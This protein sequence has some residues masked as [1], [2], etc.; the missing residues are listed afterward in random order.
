MILRLTSEEIEY[1]RDRRYR[2]TR[3]LRVKTIEEALE[4]V[5]D[6]GFCFAF[7]AR[8]SELP[9]LWHAACGERNP[10]MPQ[11]TH[12]DPYIGLVWQ[13]KDVLSAQRQIYY[14]KALKKRPTMISLHY[15]P[16]FYKLSGKS[17]DPEQYAAEYMRGDLSVAA[18]RIMDALTE[19]TPQITR[20]LKLASG[21][22]SPQKRYEFDQ[23]IAELQ[24]KMYMVK[25]A[26]FYDPFTFLWDLVPNQFPEAIQLASQISEDDARREIL[27]KYFENVF[28]ANTSQI[29]RLFAW[30]K[31]VT[32]EILALLRDEGFLMD[33]KIVDRSGEWLGLSEEIG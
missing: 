15:F 5:N 1:L 10:V 16:Y 24:M 12:H 4:F 6:V 2:R 25:I 8:N 26:E 9:C 22:S 27:K 20:D 30:P 17:G 23:G 3:L 14:G 29:I 11:H 13:A 28:V 33:V 18:R 21:Y 19:Q 31:Q 32:E 7:S